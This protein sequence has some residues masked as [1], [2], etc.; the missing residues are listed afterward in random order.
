[1]TTNTPPLPQLNR[2]GVARLDAIDL[3]R[4]LV[5]ALMVLD[6]VR[7]FFHADAL[8][9]NPVDPQRTTVVLFATRWITHLCAPTFVFLSGASI[10][11]QRLNGRDARSL[12]RYLI[13]RGMCLILLEFTVVSFGFNFG[14]MLFVQVIY[15]IG[16]GMVALGVLTFLPVRAVLAIG[17]LI[18]VGHNALGP[19]NAT[20]FG[21]AAALWI[22]ALEL[23]PTPVLPGFVAYPAIPWLGIM[24]LGYGLGPVFTSDAVRRRRV[25]M[26]LGIGALLLF[27]VLRTINAYG[28]PAAWRAQAAT[29]RTVLSFLDVSKYP[30]SL[31]YVLATLGVSLLLMPWLERLRGLG[32]RVLL[33]YGRTPLFTY[34]IHVYLVHGSAMIVGA[35]AGI[36]ASYFTN[37]LLDPQRLVK[38]VWGY[39]LSVVYLVWLL[40]LVALYPLSQWFAGV[41]RSRRDAWL[42][43]L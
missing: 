20:S 34:L 19:I 2:L 11:L 28:D 16:V 37:F 39:N 13:A 33:A 3:L 7:D 30:P 32:A 12:S 43:Y 24:C 17:V 42:G 5:I 38:A 1:M 31:M 29:W 6:H 21:A 25:L 26:T 10:Y 8:L 14:V 23:G 9:F 36:P 4:G 35:A 22:F 40:T 15:A 41:K 18:V 27:L